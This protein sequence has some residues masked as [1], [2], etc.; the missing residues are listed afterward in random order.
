LL[1]YHFL[2]QKKKVSFASST[3]FF[4]NY[5]AGGNGCSYVGEKEIFPIMVEEEEREREREGMLGSEAN[6]GFNWVLDF[7]IKFESGG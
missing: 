6:I 1:R 4:C 3:I 5:P 2:L 7:F